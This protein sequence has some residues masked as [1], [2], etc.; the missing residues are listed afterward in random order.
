MYFE[1]ILFQSRGHSRF[2]S[3]VHGF[4]S[5]RQWGMF[6]VAGMNFLLPSDVYIQSDDYWF[7]PVVKDHYCAF[8]GT[9]PYGHSWDLEAL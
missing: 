2:S 3:G 4:A 7:P 9:S 6:I 5:H 8:E 1:I